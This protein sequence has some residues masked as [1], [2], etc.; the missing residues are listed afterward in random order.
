MVECAGDIDEFL[1]IKGTPRMLNSAMVE[2]THDC[3]SLGVREPGI[4][5]PHLQRVRKTI[6]IGR[7]RNL[8]GPFDESPFLVC[9]GF[10]QC[11]ATSN[12][13]DVSMS[14]F[15]TPCP[16][17]ETYRRIGEL[18]RDSSTYLEA[19]FTVGLYLDEGRLISVLTRR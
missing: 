17:S 15:D 2:I 9:H 8:D 13:C 1:A 19:G 11:G 7:R 10:R 16:Q 12:N 6:F 3:K 4:V 5:L 18:S 14:C